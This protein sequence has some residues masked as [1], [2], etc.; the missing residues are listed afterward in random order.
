M[1]K[2]FKQA[3]EERRSIYGIC[4][5][6][7]VSDDQIMEIV[8]N[9]VKHVPSAFNS[10]SSRVAVLLGD[11]HQKL[12]EIVMETLKKIVPPE[13]FSPTEQKI[14][15]FAGGY[16]T[17]LYFDETQ[18][19]N[20]LMEKFPTYKD[21]FPV[22]AEQS[23]GMLQFAIWSQ[24]EEAGLGVNLQHYNPV[25]DEAVKKA[26]NIPDSWR[27]I[28]QMPFGK[29]TAKAGEKEFAP[30]DERVILV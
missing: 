28:A 9:S 1:A 12:W 25:I 16:G 4:S 3:M 26:F 21:N 29:P 10:Q 30:V 2:D 8:K 19:T 7:P 22:W 11:K 5:D 24:L 18:I 13:H 20:G 23:N 14:Y 27:L 15:S 17:L 6:C